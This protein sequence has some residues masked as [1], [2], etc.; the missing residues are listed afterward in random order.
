MHNS[1]VLIPLFPS[2]NIIT[3][4][5]LYDNSQPKY[6]QPLYVQPNILMLK[7]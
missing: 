2:T 3:D 5:D 6:D 4:V 7:Y 1:N